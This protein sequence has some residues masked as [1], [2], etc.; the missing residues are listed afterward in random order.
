MTNSR[1]NILKIDIGS[2]HDVMSTAELNLIADMTMIERARVMLFGLRL[3]SFCENSTV[4][5]K[6]LEYLASLGG[7]MD[8]KSANQMNQALKVC[9]VSSLSASALYEDPDI[10]EQPNN[11]EEEKVETVPNDSSIISTKFSI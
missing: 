11:Y 3:R 9:I 6:D 1:K 7:E 4:S 10:V 5:Y 8:D 2:Q